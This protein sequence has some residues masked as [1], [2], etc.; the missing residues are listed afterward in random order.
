MAKNSVLGWNKNWLVT[1]VFDFLWNPL[2]VKNISSNVFR[3]VIKALRAVRRAISFCGFS[4]RL[5]LNEN[6]CWN[7]GKQNQPKS[8]VF[9]KCG[10]CICWCWI[11][12]YGE[13][14]FQ[15]STHINKQIMVCGF[16]RHS[17]NKEEKFKKLFFLNRT[18]NRKCIMVRQLTPHPMLKPH[19]LIS[20]Q[21]WVP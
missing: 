16:Q 19:L 12:D 8:N 18:M 6:I 14:N 7:K 21:C 5:F 9:L 4:N 13:N 20:S 2:K 17:L 10:R 15:K 11:C 3:D 1:T